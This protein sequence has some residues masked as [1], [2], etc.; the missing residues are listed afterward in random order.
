MSGVVAITRL[1]DLQRYG[2]YRLLPSQ[3]QRVIDMAGAIGSFP[4]SCL[5]AGLTLSQY[6]SV[7]VNPVSR[8]LKANVPVLRHTFPNQTSDATFAAFDESVPQDLFIAARS[9]MLWLQEQTE[10]PTLASITAPCVGGSVAG[11]GRGAG[12]PV[13]AVFLPALTIVGFIMEEYK[14]RGQLVPGTAPCGWFLE[15]TEIK[16]SDHRPAVLELEEAYATALGDK[17]VDNAAWR[18]STAHRR[19]QVYTNIGLA[20][21]WPTM[22]AQPPIAPFIPLQDILRHGERVQ[23]WQP[24][25][26]GPAQPPNAAGK[27]LVVYP[28]HLR[29]AGSHQ[30]RAATLTPQQLQSARYR[31]DPLNGWGHGPGVTWYQGTLAVPTATQVEKSMG[32]R[33]GYTAAY[34]PYHPATPISQVPRLPVAEGDRVARLGDAWDPNAC[35][36]AIID[37]IASSA[38]MPAPQTRPSNKRPRPPVPAPSSAPK[39]PRASGPPTPAAPAA[40]QEPR[41]DPQASADL[42]LDVG[43]LQHEAAAWAEE[44]V[45][46]DDS[47]LLETEFQSCGMKPVLPPKPEDRQP[48][49]RQSVVATLKPGSA[50][51]ATARYQLDSA[52]RF[53]EHLR[54]KTLPAEALLPDAEFQ[55]LVID[56]LTNPES[57]FR[58]GNVHAHRRLWHEF[59]TETQGPQSTQ[60]PHVKRVLRVLEHG[61][62]PQWVN[63]SAA[64]QQLHPKWAARMRTMRKLL[65]R[66]YPEARVDE[67]MSGD[68]PG[69]VRLPNLRSCDGHTEFVTTEI[70]E[71]LRSGRIQE[72]WWPDGQPPTCI[73]PL[74]VAVRAITGKLRLIFDGRYINLFAKYVPFKYESLA[75]ILD[76]T[77]KGSWASVSDI[78]AGYH[79][80]LLPEL[81]PFMGIYWQ[82]TVYVWTVLPFGYGPACRIFTEVTSAMFKPLR[83]AGIAL[84]SYIDDRFSANPQAAVCKLEVLAQFAVMAALGW[85]VNAAKSVITPSQDVEFLGPRIDLQLGRFVVPDKKLKLI[86]TQLSSAI[87]APAA[88]TGREMLSIVGRI[89]ATR[90]AVPLAPLLS[91]HI[92]LLMRNN[93]SLQSIVPD[94]DLALHVLRYLHDTYARY[95]GKAF[96]KP[97]GG[98]VFAGDAGEY[99]AGGFTVTG[100]VARPFVFSF[101][102]EQLQ[103]V[104]THE[105]HSTAREIYCVMLSVMALIETI[106]DQLRHSRLKYV[107]DSQ[108]AF[109]TIMGMLSQTY[110]DLERVMTIWQAC[111]D[112]D[113]AFSMAWS[114]R[115]EPHMQRADELSKLEDNTAWGLADWAFNQIITDLQVDPADIQLDPFAQPEFHRAARWF[116]LFN[117][118]GSSGVDGFSQKWR[119]ADGSKP[120]LCWVNGPFHMIGRVLRKVAAERVDCIVIAP[121]WTQHWSALLARDLPVH[122]LPL[123]GAAPPTAPVPQLSSPALESAPSAEKGPPSGIPQLTW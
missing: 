107:T 95:N 90:L 79:A 3:S 20:Q 56:R 118:V 120:K 70:Q 4:L 14:A 77:S 69:Q 80:L 34:V 7:E 96:W 76:Y 116:S 92:Y 35:T 41:P 61:V 112:N 78:K 88:V 2:R 111:A 57:Q 25:Y 8:V 82:G 122:A 38:R 91:R 31:A 99:G 68:A 49:P 22:S 5:Q 94:P 17:A 72:W 110:Q 23:T 66:F 93:Q 9:A 42:A 52:F 47:W 11:A 46:S 86:L 30:W 1:Q 105:F 10:L 109:H 114:P 58:P 21:D 40:A 55:Q 59:L 63:P 62:Q 51:M 74:G 19:A 85:Y 89:M 81:S 24:S 84:T 123:S 98:I 48:P 83:A 101:T 121:K 36:F 115:E 43:T 37:R 15:T 104:A 50:P 87:A 67:L 44:P 106:P 64:S 27:P 97:P 108:A 13:G 102:P 12:T 60:Q 117:T 65:A 75:D 16:P 73:L 32:Y 54:A 113:I 119:M 33:P 53:L 71:L 100:E 18:G 39:R 6:Q 26:H 29:T 45:D 28:K 103:A